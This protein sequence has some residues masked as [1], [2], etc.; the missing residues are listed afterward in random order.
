MKVEIKINEKGICEYFRID[1]KEYGTG[2]Y[3]L[4]IHVEPRIKPVIFIKC[5]SDE[6]I[7][8][9]DDTKLYIDNS[10]KK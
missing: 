8:S 5:R 9:S 7:M 1:G 6:F 3:A 4:D 2:V 10:N